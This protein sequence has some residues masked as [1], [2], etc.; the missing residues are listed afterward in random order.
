VVHTVPIDIIVAS[1]LDSGNSV[2]ALFIFFV[3][4]VIALFRLLRRRGRLVEPE[5]PEVQ[6]EPL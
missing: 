3:L 6:P 5:K 4:L 1:H 2:L